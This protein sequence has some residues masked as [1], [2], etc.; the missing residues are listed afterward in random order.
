[1]EKQH[2]I[3]KEPSEFRIILLD[4]QT[5]LDT[6]SY[7][8]I[9]FKKAKAD[10]LQFGASLI[11]MALLLQMNNKASE[12]AEKYGVTTNSVFGLMLSEVDDKEKFFNFY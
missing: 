5:Y 7:D 8:I 3:E 10:K 11:M 2:I 9:R 6:L 1:M 12:L 4:V